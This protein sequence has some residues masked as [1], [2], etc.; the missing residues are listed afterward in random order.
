MHVVHICV[1][2]HILYNYKAV[3]L[4]YMNNINYKNISSAEVRYLEYI[5]KNIVYTNTYYLCV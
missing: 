3:F 2:I 1:Q 4:I 5:T